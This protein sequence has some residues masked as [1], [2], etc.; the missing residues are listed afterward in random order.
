[1]YSPYNVMERPFPVLN[2][3]TSFLV[4]ISPHQSQICKTPDCVLLCIKK[5]WWNC[6]WKCLMLQKFGSGPCFLS[7]VDK[8]SNPVITCGNA[9]SL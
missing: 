4:L 1:M 7:L 9:Y 3:G 8:G 2:Y 5:L 6:I